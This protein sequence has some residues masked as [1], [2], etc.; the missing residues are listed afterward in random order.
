MFFSIINQINPIKEQQRNI[1]NQP[2]Q[3]KKQEITADMES[4]PPPAKNLPKQ[5]L[6]TKHLFLNKNL[7]KSFQNKPKT[8]LK[9][10]AKQNPPS[11]INPTTIP[12]N[13]NLQN[14]TLKP[15]FKN[16]TL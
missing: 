14:K 1:N 12:Q 15:N 5:H 8:R 13:K 16:K 3:Q 4:E 7:Q 10:K 6:Q 9:H 2:T 11:K